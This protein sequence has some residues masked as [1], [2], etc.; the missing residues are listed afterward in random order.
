M[1]FLWLIFFVSLPLIQ[2]LSQYYQYLYQCALILKI[3]CVCACMCVCVCT[4]W[5]SAIRRD[6][7]FRHWAKAFEVFCVCVFV[8]EDIRNGK[9]LLSLHLSVCICALEKG[10]P[11]LCW[12]LC[13]RE[14]ETSGPGSQLRHWGTTYVLC[15]YCNTSNI[16]AYTWRH[17]Q[18]AVQRLLCLLS[19]IY[20]NYI[21]PIFKEL[22]C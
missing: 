10:A 18:R 16:H 2:F 13:T 17:R 12:L 6:W 22:L 21:I 9:E 1:E 3:V 5:S 7:V 14:D 15:M 11:P 19:D 4:L 20:V 8:C